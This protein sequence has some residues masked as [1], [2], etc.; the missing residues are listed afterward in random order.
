MRKRAALRSGLNTKH[1]TTAGNE[2]DGNDRRPSN[3]LN[4]PKR[5]EADNPSEM[6]SHEGRSSAGSASGIMSPKCVVKYLTIASKILVLFSFIKTSF[7]SLT[8]IHSQISQ[9]ED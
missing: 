9:S 4:L 7:F 6:S 2:S 1:N 5:T 3:V 8:S